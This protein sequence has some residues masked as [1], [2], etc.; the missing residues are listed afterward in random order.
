MK[1]LNMFT[2]RGLV[3]LT[4]LA[5]L[6]LPV[7]A[8]TPN[9]QTVVRYRVKPDRV[10]DFR[11]AV[12]DYSAILKKANYDESS[13][14]LVAQSGEPIYFL[15]RRHTGFASLD[16][17]GAASPKLK[18]FRADLARATARQNSCIESRERTVSEILADSSLPLPTEMPRMF[19]V[20]RS[21]VKFDHIADYQESI[22]ADVLPA[23]K[24][25]GVK[26]YTTTRIRYGGP[27]N[28]FVSAQGID[29]WADLDKPSPMARAMGAEEARKSLARRAP[30]L[31]EVEIQVV[32]LLPELSYIAPAQ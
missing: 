23:M 11:A 7:L 29:N 14:W 2:R 27:A 31:S 24:K 26:Y 25:A 32:R 3:A 4:L 8:Q 18:E 19:R 15:V 1:N 9:L 12:A 13:Y 16:T 30:F 22:K 5:G 17:A 28:V 10:A 6:G 21:T 20:T